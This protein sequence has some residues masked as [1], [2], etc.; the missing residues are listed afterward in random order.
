MNYQAGVKWSLMNSP[1]KDDEYY[2]AQ[3]QLKALDLL[4]KQLGL[5]KQQIQ[6]D[7]STDIVIN[8]GE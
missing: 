1:E 2:N 7:V 5:Q 8:I 6:A 3:A 4:Q